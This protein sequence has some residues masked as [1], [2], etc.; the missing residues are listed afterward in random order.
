MIATWKVE[1]NPELSL[2]QPGV[3]PRAQAKPPVAS[4][5]AAKAPVQDTIAAAAA[6]VQHPWM[7]DFAAALGTSANSAGFVGTARAEVGVRRR[8]LGL[9]IAFTGDTSR[10]QAVETGTATWRRLTLGAGPSFVALEGPV[11]VELLAQLFVGFTS[12]NG[13]NY[14]LNRQTSDVSPGVASAVRV[15]RGRGWVRPWLE[16]GGQFWFAPQ[17]IEILKDNPPATSV[18]LP[19]T[20]ARLMVGISFLLPW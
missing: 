11:A 4:A 12:V 6:P 3:Y 7:F 18:S 10:D 15:A 5:P 9:R 16:L 13:Q 1:R 19:R 17:A 2:L 8:R 14:D 20:D